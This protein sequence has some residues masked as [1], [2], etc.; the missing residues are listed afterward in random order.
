MRSKM[1]IGGHDRHMMLEA[2]KDSSCCAVFFV[3]S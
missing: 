1:G 3:F 2:K